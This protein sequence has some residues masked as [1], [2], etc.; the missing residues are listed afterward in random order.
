MHI[1]TNLV[2]PQSH[3]YISFKEHLR[4]F[5]YI[6]TTCQS[7][8]SALLFSLVLILQWPLIMYLYQNYT[9][10][11]QHLYNVSK[12]GLREL[13]L[14]CLSRTHDMRHE[15][16]LLL[17]PLRASCETKNYLQNIEMSCISN[18]LKLNDPFIYKRNLRSSRDYKTRYK[19]G[20]RILPFT[21]P[22]YGI[23]EKHY[24]V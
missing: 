4:E 13:V 24:I 20:D 18:S 21:I 19:A 16:S 22:N 1:I 3:N 23:T 9:I 17:K 6:L 10:R 15:S 12:V 11:L 7:E 2:A 8:M 5:A 14:S